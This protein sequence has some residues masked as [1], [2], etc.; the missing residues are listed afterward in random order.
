MCHPDSDYA[1]LLAPALEDKARPAPRAAI[2]AQARHLEAV[3]SPILAAAD[4]LGLP[5]C[6]AG[7]TCR[8]AAPERRR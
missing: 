7:C 2:E 1:H 8:G 6:P 5:D 3:R 4:A